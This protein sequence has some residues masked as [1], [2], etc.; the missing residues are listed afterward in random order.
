MT[1]CTTLLAVLALF[2][3]G[4][5]VL[6]GFAFVLLFGILVGTYSTIYVA[7][8]IVLFWE[9]RFGGKDGGTRVKGA[10]ERAPRPPA[11]KSARQAG[12]QGG[13]QPPL[14]IL[15]RRPSGAAGY[16]HL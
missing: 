2:L 13:D 9:K 12:D 6:R 11:A 10:D 5:D 1:A 16:P 7:S 3:V 15:S 8:A 14:R 4:G